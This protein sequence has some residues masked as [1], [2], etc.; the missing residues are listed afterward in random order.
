MASAVPNQYEEIS[1]FNT[2]AAKLVAR[3]PEIFADKK[4][5]RI[6]AV[7]I[8]NKDRPERRRQL[9]ELRPVVPPINLFC[10]KE[11]VVT[12]YM[13]DWIVMSDKHKALVVSTV[14]HSISSEGHG[15]TVAFDMKD[16]SVMLR[17]FGVDYL[18]NGDV[19][20]IINEQISWR[21]SSPAGE[22][23]L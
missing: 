13:N 20:D 3:Y 21:V 2:I 12:F 22:E 19:P 5:D 4:V 1:D 16:H 6:A 8:T 9:F 14:L 17:T 10:N 23:K 18:D 11:Y 7:A 15:K